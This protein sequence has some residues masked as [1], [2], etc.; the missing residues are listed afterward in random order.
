VQRFLRIALVVMA[1]YV[2]WIFISRQAANRRWT[3]QHVKKAPSGEINPVYLSDGV[4]ILQFYARD[5]VITEGQ[6]TVI[7]YGVVNAKSVTIAPAVGG[8]GAAINRCIDAAPEHDTEYMLTAE[9][10]DGRAVSE[11]LKV[12]V[13][14][15]EEM[16]PQI[17]S[18]G[19][20]ARKSDY[21]GR[22][23]FLLSFGARNAEEVRID[24]PV[25]EPLHR[26]PIGQFYVAPKQTTTY[27]LTVTG[28][29]GHVARK[30][31]TVELPAK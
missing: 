22:P 9:G 10:A 21:L 6:S 5:A 1:A 27:T 3:E 23:V 24:P 30:Q 8:V 11:S 2:A 16:L 26:S 14:A 12:R 17:T 15:D 31:V 4:K 7:C 28:K 25:F 29:R 19:V 20:A 13:K 18:F